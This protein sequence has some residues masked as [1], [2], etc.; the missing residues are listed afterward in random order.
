MKRD[1]YFRNQSERLR[2]DVKKLGVHTACYGILYI[3]RNVSD[4]SK[5]T[6]APVVFT[7]A[8]HENPKVKEVAAECMEQI[9]TF[10]REF[11]ASQQQWYRL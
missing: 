11:R 8:I 1:T 3:C 7:S 6:E 9:V 5:S 4:P 10:E 2:D